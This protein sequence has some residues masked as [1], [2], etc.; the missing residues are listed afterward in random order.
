MFCFGG[1]AQFFKCRW[2]EIYRQLDVNTMCFVNSIAFLL[3]IHWLSMPI[4]R[5]G[6][7]HPLT[8]RLGEATKLKGPAPNVF[9]F[10][11]LWAVVVLLCQ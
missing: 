5:S 9:L 2:L 8:L 6:A 3:I 7:D 1:Y 10:A 4:Y 11:H